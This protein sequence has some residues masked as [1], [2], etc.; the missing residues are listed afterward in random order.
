MRILKEWWDKGMEEV[1]L[2]GGDFNARSGEGG[3]KIEM[4]EEREER[5][6][7]DKTVN[8]DGRRLLEE[9]REMGLEIL[10]GGIKGDEEGEYT[11]IG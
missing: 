8:G 11:Y 3:G 4:E 10:N 6:S 5:R 1:V 7:K 2:I 9:L